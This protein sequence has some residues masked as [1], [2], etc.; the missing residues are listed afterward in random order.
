MCLLEMQVRL[1]AGDWVLDMGTGTGILAIAAARL[2]AA[3]VVAVDKDIRA[4]RVARA[5]VRRNG[6]DE[7]VAVVAG[8]PAA[9]GPR[10]PFDLVV[11][12]L[13]ST[14]DVGTWLT[15]L[16]QACRAGG[17]VILSGMRSPDQ[18]PPLPALRGAHLERI[19]E[20]NRDNWCTLALGKTG[21]SPRPPV[22]AEGEA[23]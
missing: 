7:V 5:N 14:R 15:S 21:G 18:G 9:L 6:L 1:R 13:D 12:N 16:S 23:G 22:V 17:T 3:R 20:R 10:A 8:T 11:A 2:S 4:C 19:E